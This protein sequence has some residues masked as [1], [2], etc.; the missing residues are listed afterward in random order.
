MERVGSVPNERGPR[1]ERH[2]SNTLGADPGKNDLSR[3]CSETLRSCKDWFVNRAAR[4][5]GDRTDEILGQCVR[6]TGGFPDN[7]ARLL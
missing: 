2:N 4:V 5:T 3:C 6:S 1:D 7:Y